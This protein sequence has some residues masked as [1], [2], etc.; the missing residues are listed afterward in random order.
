MDIT[1]EESPVIHET[2]ELCQAILAQPN[3]RSIRQRI[4]TFMGDDKA[5]AQ[6]ES[7]VNK[8]ETLQHKQQMSMP[9]SGEEVADF[10][11]DR[12][13]LMKN[14]IARDFLDAQEQLH[15]VRQ[16][17]QQYVSKTLELGRL[18]TDEEMNGCCGGHGG[19]GCSH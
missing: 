9:L 19:C 2:K 10:E 14:P 8:G 11:K 16:S 17:I 7:L 4:D 3:L 1:I 6:Y 13:A 15:E 5:R 18:P 12:D